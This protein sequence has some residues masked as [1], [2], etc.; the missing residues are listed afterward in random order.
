MKKGQTIDRRRS[1][2]SLLWLG[3]QATR[4]ALIQQSLIANNIEVCKSKHSEKLINMLRILHKRTCNIHN[5]N[6]ELYRKI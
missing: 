4:R 1:D 3:L 5:E 6:Y 2:G